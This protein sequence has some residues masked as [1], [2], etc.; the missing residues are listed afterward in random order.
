[1]QP[2]LPGETASELTR[3]AVTPDALDMLVTSR[4]HDVKAAVMVD[5]AP[6]GWIFALLTLQTMEG[7]PRRWG[8]MA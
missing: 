2:A 7:V 6:D 5:A 8:T 1:M 3:M 4:N